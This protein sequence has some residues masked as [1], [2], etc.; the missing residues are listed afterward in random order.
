MRI[1]RLTTWCPELEQHDAKPW[2]RRRS[3]DQP[4]SCT[5]LAETPPISSFHD[6]SVCKR[7]SGGGKRFH[8][9]KSSLMLA[10]SKQPGHLSVI[11][12]VPVKSVSLLLNLIEHHAGVLYGSRVKCLG[13]SLLPKRDISSCAQYCSV[14]SGP[15]FFSCPCFF[16]ICSICHVAHLNPPSDSPRRKNPG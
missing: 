13:G 14:D 8:P 7:S 3:S 9:Q 4:D 11:I 1:R 12:S 16:F 10:T 5:H 15:A 6:S 2:D